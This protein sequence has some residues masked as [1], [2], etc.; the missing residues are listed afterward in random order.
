MNYA[1]D[2]DLF[3]TWAEAVLTGT[4]APLTHRYNA[5][6][7]FK[8]AVGS[9]HITRVEGLDA[10]LTAYADNVCVLDLL[11]IGAHRRDWR[12]TLLS[13]GMIIVRHPELETLI[14]LGDRFARDLQLYAG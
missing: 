14:E 10:L 6:S 2:G 3:Q 12:A 9:G 1:T 8:R 5:A 7:I 4:S 11:P 13:D